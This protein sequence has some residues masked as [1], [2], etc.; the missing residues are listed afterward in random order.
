M[1]ALYWSM[2]LNAAQFATVVVLIVCLVHYAREG[3]YYKGKCEMHDALM[4]EART[5]PMER[6]S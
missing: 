5:V 2:G 4:D 3:T 6:R 1:T